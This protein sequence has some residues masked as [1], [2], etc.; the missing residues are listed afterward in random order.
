MLMVL[1][2]SVL[3]AASMLAAR[4]R[5]LRLPDGAAAQH[6]HLPSSQTGDV[7]RADGAAVVP[8]NGRALRQAQVAGA[9][10]CCE[11]MHGPHVCTVRTS[12]RLK[13]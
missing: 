10:P 2:S 1:L 3:A 4:A 8:L 6:G 11:R 5:P 12:C 9:H 13:Q 7:L